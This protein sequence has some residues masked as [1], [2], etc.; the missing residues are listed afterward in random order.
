MRS[1]DA[2][3]YRNAL[4]HGDC[5]KLLPEVPAGIVDLVVTDPPYNIASPYALTR[6]N[7]RVMT[8][9]EAWGPWDQYREDDYRQLLAD[10]FR[11]LYRVL[12]PAGQAYCW[13]GSRYVSTAIALAGDA[14]F[15]FRA[16]IVAVKSRPQPSLTL[17]NWRSAYEEALY[18]SKG[19]PRPFHFSSQARMLNV[20]YPPYERKATKHPTG[21]AAGDARAPHPRVVEPG[22]P[23]PRP[24]PGQRHHRGRCPVARPGLPRHRSGPGLPRH[25]P[26]P[27]RSL[28]SFVTPTHMG[29]DLFGLNPSDD[30]GQYFRNNIWYWHPLWEYVTE[31][32]ADLLTPQQVTTGHANEGVQV[33]ADTAAAIAARLTG[34]LDAGRVRRYREAVREG[35]GDAAG[36]AVRALRCHGHARR[37]ARHR[38]VQRLRR[39][40][41][42]S[43]VRDALPVRRAERP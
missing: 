35:P 20:L 38:H 12:R 14:G 37:R 32:C 15:R 36:R 23:R 42:G 2:D 33:D 40:R 28:T 39:P 4:L 21:E 26:A 13:I 31:Q 24:V 17:D 22:R 6:S 41:E 27:P 16:K 1:T 5:R 19:R 9:A 25:G 30:R 34:L 8:T 43:A 7:G 29:F 18:F 10:V 3:V 11:Q